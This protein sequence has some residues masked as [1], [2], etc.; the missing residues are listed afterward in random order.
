MDEIEKIRIALAE[1]FRKG[2][3]DCP[4]RPDPMLDEDGKDMLHIRYGMKHTKASKKLMAEAKYKPES[5]KYNTLYMREYRKGITRGQPDRSGE[6]NP[7]YGRDFSHTAESKAKISKA[8]RG[9][10]NPMY[11][12]KRPDVVA[13]NKARKKNGK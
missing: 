7:A 6:N 10:N 8:N 11:G 2:D 13:R 9:E 1:Q 5:T 3:P 4:E 12:R